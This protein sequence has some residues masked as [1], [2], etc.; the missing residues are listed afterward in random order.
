MS[1]IDINK[2]YR[3]RSGKKVKLWTTEAQCS[4]YRIK[5]EVEVRHNEWIYCSWFAC[6][7]YSRPSG[8]HH[9]DL[10]EVKPR[11][12]L[13]R[14]VSVFPNGTAGFYPSREGADFCSNSTRIACVK[15]EIDCEEGE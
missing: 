5:G 11:I 3:T 4:I 9:L 2:T 7:Q 12:K 15:I 14:W 1:K 13:E 10:V 6:G 8:P